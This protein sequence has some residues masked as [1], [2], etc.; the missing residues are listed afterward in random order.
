LTVSARTESKQPTHQLLD[1]GLDELG[2]VES[3]DRL[4]VVDVL[5]KHGDG[6]GVG[7]SA[8]GVAALLE[9]ELDLLVCGGDE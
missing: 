2:E 3:L 8:E 4:A 7:V 1:D 5:G 9:Y 6:F